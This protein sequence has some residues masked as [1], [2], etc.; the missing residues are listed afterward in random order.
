MDEVAKVIV[1]KRDVLEL[2]SVNFLAG[3]NIL[4]EDFPGMAKTL[5]A[6]T[7]AR[8]AGC[9]FG[10]VQFTPDVLPGDITGASIYDQKSGEFK[11]RPGPVFTN[12]LLADEI[13][14]APPKTQAALLEA[15][16]ERQVTIEGQTY[17]LPKPYIVMATQN[18]A[19]QEGCYPLPEAQLDRFLM[20]LSVGY[21]SRQDESEILRR[22]IARGKDDSDVKTV[23]NPEQIVAM[24][25][26]VELVHIDTSL[27]DY[28]SD[29]VCRTREH[30]DIY[31]GSSPRGSQA[32]LKASR[33]LAAMRGRTFVT[34]DDIKFLA[35]H[36][37]SHRLILKPEARI[38]GVKATS[39][40]A[41]VLAQATV[42]VLS[43]Q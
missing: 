8:A 19:E 34:P 14:R 32:M 40:V 18:P 29:I 24:Q 1:G 15:M 28:L 16:Q 23:A 13:N 21:P 37:L 9:D 12:V 31:V 6:N 41:D 2:V 39:V 20:R 36:V 43:R 25:N 38:R 35:P 27:V 5:M 10:R 11:F 30:A 17:K 22:R 7:F 4:F 26:A 3:G 33:A 42:P